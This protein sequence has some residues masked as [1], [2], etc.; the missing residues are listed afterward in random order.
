MPEIFPSRYRSENV[1]TE[2]QELKDEVE[3]RRELPAPAAR[4]ALREA[5]G[6]SLDG[7]ARAVGV[8]KQTVLGWESGAFGPRG[9][10]LSA[11]L[12]VLRIFRKAMSE[13]GAGLKEVSPPTGADT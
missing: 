7:V 9:S 10:N 12:E 13:D 2:L 3:A 11:Y 4:R 8:S 1:N 6:V 5:A